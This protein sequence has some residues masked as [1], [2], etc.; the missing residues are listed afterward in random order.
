MLEKGEVVSNNYKLLPVDIRDLQNL[1]NMIN[2]TQLDPR[3]IPILVNK[4]MSTF[5]SM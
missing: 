5:S 1:D 3:Y 4:L 2:I